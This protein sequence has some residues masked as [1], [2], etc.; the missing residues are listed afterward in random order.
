MV[1]AAAGAGRRRHPA[2]GAT[3]PGQPFGVGGRGTGRSSYAAARPVGDGCDGRGQQRRVGAAERALEVVAVDHELQQPGQQVVVAGDRSAPGLEHLARNRVHGLE[4]LGRRT[5]EP[6]D[7]VVA[8]PRRDLTGH[9]RDLLGRGRVG[10][11]VLA[12]RQRH[13]AGL[14]GS[15]EPRQPDAQPEVSHQ[16][17][18]RPVAEPDRLDEVGTHRHL[19]EPVREHGVLLLEQRPHV[20]SRSLLWAARLWAC[21]AWMSL[22]HSQPGLAEGRS[23][24]RRDHRRH[25]GRARTR[26]PVRSVRVPDQLRRRTRGRG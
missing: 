8:E 15:D 12:E 5:P 9:L 20:A 22:T 6:T 13:R 10:A 4:R 1:T 18:H 23:A 21:P 2:G 11:D 26:G 17:A 7:Q 14:G 25:A 3:D 19:V 16:L 24:G